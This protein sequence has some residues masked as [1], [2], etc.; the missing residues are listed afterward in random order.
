MSPIS[1]F[2]SS[3]TSISSKLFSSIS[4]F[5][6]DIKSKITSKLF[7]LRCFEVFLNICITNSPR[8][9]KINFFYLLF[10]LCNKLIQISVKT[11][12]QSSLKLLTSNKSFNISAYSLVSFKKRIRTTRLNLTT[13]LSRDDFVSSTL[14]SPTNCL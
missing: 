10:P 6:C 3:F 1:E 2:S 14:I 4:G 8:V 12:S 13:D 11:F 5:S 7:L 9:A